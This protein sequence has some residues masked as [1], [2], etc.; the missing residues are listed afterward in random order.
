MR[1]GWLAVLMVLVWTGGARAQPGP[2]IVIFPAEG[3]VSGKLKKAPAAVTAAVAEAARASGA[4]TEVAAGSVDDAMTLAGCDD[5][6]PDCL[7]KVASTVDADLVVAISVAAADSGVF[8]DIDI[9]RRDGSEPVRANWILDGADAAAIQ[10]A[11]AREARSLFSGDQ[12]PAA[13]TGD[14]PGPAAPAAAVEVPREA[15]PAPASRP[16]EDRPSGLRRVRWYAWATAAAGAALIAA[17][18]VYLSGAA[19]KQDDIDA[20]SPSSLADF[21]DLEALEDD[22][23]SQALTGNVLLGAGIVAAGVGVTMIILQARSSPDEA[24]DSAVSLAPAAFDR[25]A[26]VSLTV[27]G[28]L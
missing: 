24:E 12:P 17:G 15:G 19:S 22:A 13:A 16:A 11:A 10:K 3:A 1:T 5:K 7:G 8:V 14:E 23:E 18:G 27:R 4:R 6:Q 21:R 2:R 28:D 26:G 20:A 25:G 9:G